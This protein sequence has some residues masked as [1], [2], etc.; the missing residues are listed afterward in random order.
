M[1]RFGLIGYP[2]GHSYSREFFNEKF[3]NLGLK[4]HTYDLMEMEY[5]KEFPAMWLRYTDLIGV[6]VTVPH[7]ENVIR[8]LDYKDISVIKVGAANVIMKRNGKLHGYNTDYLSFKESLGNWI[9]NYKGEALILGS[10]GSSKAVQAALD[11]LKIDC[12]Q[13]SRLKTKGDYTYDQLSKQPEIIKRFQLIVN[14][15][16]LGMYPNEDTCPDI[17]YEHLTKNHF[18]FDLVYNPEET[19]FMKKGAQKG[20]KVKNGLEMLKLQ[21]E[22]S[23]DIWSNS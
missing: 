17:P 2:L 4:D 23:W 16:P 9:G 6:N 21:A 18:L 10:G 22:R 11:E 7:K 14:T 13:V 5:L 19:S 8:F 20:A 3:K 12:Y 1:R 15:T